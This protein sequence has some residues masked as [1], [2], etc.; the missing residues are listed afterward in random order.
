MICDCIK[1][2]MDA[3]GGLEFMLAKW[4]FNQNSF[5]FAAHANCE[6]GKSF[7]V[8]AVRMSKPQNK[9]SLWTLILIKFLIAH[10]SGS[11]TDYIHLWPRIRCV[12][13]NSL[14]TQSPWTTAY[15]CA[16]LIV[17]IENG[18]AGD[19]RAGT[20]FQFVKALRSG[21]VDCEFDFVCGLRVV[22][23]GPPGN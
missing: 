1:C 7:R 6:I 18:G 20:I 11:A 5:P 22:R 14:H 9:S 15:G 16:Q 2:G 23:N 8:V 12:H 19:E 21:N 3:S 10:F 17:T 13:C 4:I